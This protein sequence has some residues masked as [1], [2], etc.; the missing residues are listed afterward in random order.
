[1]KQ[2]SVYSI[3]GFC[4]ADLGNNVVDKRSITG[5]TFSITNQ[6]QD[7]ND[8]RHLCYDGSISWRATYQ[9]TISTS[10]NMSEYISLSTAGQQAIYLFNLLSECKL[11]K[12]LNKRKKELVKDNVNLINDNQGAIA[13]ITNNRSLKGM[14]HLL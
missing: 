4:D 8:L 5:Y 12:L 7:K 11:M 13:T 1:M 2:I 10:T 6:I 9:S 14:K 3:T